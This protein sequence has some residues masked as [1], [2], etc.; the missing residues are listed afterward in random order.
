MSVQLYAAV[1]HAQQQCPVQDGWN[2]W[3]GGSNFF[4]YHEIHQSLG[5]VLNDLHH[6]VER[7]YKK[8]L[9]PSPCL[10]RQMSEREFS[11]RVAECTRPKS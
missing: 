8:N 11:G 5:V 3:C 9:K 2:L 6:H 10:A 7:E 4:L 1:R